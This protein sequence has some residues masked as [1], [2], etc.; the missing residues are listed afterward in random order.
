M[1]EA[2]IV[3]FFFLKSDSKI[4]NFILFIY[5]YSFT[6]YSAHRRVGT[7]EAW[8]SSVKALR[9]PISAKLWEQSVLRGRNE[10]KQAKT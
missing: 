7:V 9:S 6:V 1:H 5:F 4:E 8:E 2:V 3:Q 10:A